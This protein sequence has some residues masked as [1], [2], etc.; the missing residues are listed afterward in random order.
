[1]LE[2][3][4]IDWDAAYLPFFGFG[5]PGGGGF[6]AGPP[7]PDVARTICHV[8]DRYNAPPKVRLSAFEAAIV[9]SGVH[10]LNYGDRDSLGVF[11]QRPSQG[12]GTPA[13]VMN[14]D[15]RGDPVHH[16]RDPRKRRPERRAARPGRAALGLPGPLR[17][18]RAAGHALMEKYC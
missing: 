8:L 1:M 2:V 17:P 9:E 5:G 10:N 7:D 3:K 6:F 4:L 14:V 16:A 18:G 12:W 11:Q 13:Q 15:S